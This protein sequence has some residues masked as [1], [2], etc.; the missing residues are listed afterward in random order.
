MPAKNKI[1]FR[2]L[3]EVFIVH[4]YGIDKFTYGNSRHYQPKKYFYYFA[5]KDWYRID[6]IVQLEALIYTYL[7]ANNDNVLVSHVKTI[8]R[9][10]KLLYLNKC[11]SPEPGPHPYVMT[12][13]ERIAHEEYL[14]NP[15]P[16]P[17]GSG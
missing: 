17:F 8:V 1:D 16:F 4:Q 13:E 15:S 3:A 10:L 9:I 12:K 7:L 6:D 14:N 2:E 11:T 5:D